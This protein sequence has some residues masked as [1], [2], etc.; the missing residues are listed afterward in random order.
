[1]NTSDPKGKSPTSNLPSTAVDTARS[2]APAARGKTAPSKRPV[3]QAAKHGAKAQPSSKP[4]KKRTGMS[5][6]DAVAKVLTES[7]KPM[8]CIDMVER[9]RA[10][11]YWK[12]GGKTP[13]A[14]IHSAIIRE[15]KAKG[16]AARFKKTGRGLFSVA[17]R[18]AT[19]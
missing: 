3:K 15:I 2:A 1:M 9:A 14:T 19:R 10:K 11:G 5:G 18:S 17:A 12:P 8:R 6:L 16:R 7:G 13:A 4:A